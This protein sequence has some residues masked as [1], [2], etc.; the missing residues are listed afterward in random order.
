MG[1]GMSGFWCEATEETEAV[2]GQVSAA[3]DSAKEIPQGAEAE[4]EAMQP[5]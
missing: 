2:Q 5:R 1:H 3:E 4:P